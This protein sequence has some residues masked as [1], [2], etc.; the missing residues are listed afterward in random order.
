VDVEIEDPL[1][2][3]PIPMPE[4][5]LQAEEHFKQGEYQQAIE[6]Y[7]IYLDVYP[8]SKSRER[9]LFNIGLSHAL[10]PWPVRNYSK[11]EAALNIL[12]DEYPNSG[13]RNGIKL[14]FEL[15]EQIRQLD[16]NV[17]VRNAE[18]TRLEEELN[19]LKEIDLKR[20]PARPTE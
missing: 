15:I 8:E 10:A 16:R 11:S 14:I 3:N 9:V 7:Q 19:R 6:E 5:F 4:V 12:L 13:Y 20:R 1:P 18:I 17:R 2:P